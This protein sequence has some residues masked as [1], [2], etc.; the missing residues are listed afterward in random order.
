MKIIFIIFL[1]VVS[2]IFHTFSIYSNVLLQSL[3]FR[4]T[5]EIQTRS[6]SMIISMMWSLPILMFKATFRPIGGMKDDE[7]EVP[8]IF[9]SA[10]KRTVLTPAEASGYAEASGC[11][12]AV[13]ARTL[14]CSWACFA[15][16]LPQQCLVQSATCAVLYRWKSNSDDSEKPT[17]TQAI[18]VS[19]WKGWFWSRKGRRQQSLWGQWLVVE[20][21]SGDAEEDLCCRDREDAWKDA[22]AIQAAGMGHPKK[23]CRDARP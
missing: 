16:W 5:E 8:L 9:Y 21:R 14:A 22:V 17:D 2:Y 6:T 10:F 1:I 19:R 23:K 15:R 20:V 13:W 4:T 3:P 11:N 7:F 12:S 18:S